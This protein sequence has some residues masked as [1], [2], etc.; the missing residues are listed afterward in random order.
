M[1]FLKSYLPFLFSTIIPYIMISI[2]SG[3][4]FNMQHW[5]SAMYACY[6]IFTIISCGIAMNHYLNEYE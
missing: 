3:F 1:K 4:E 6:S 5:N 2:M